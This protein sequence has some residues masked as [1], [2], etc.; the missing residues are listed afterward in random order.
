MIVLLVFT[1]PGI[2]YESLEKQWL[3]YC[4]LNPNITVFFIRFSQEIDDEYVIAKNEIIIRGT[5]SFVPGIYEK[6]IRSLQ[7]LLAKDE[8]DEVNFFV[9]SNISSFWIFDRLEKYLGTVQ[10]KKFV[11]TGFIAKYDKNEKKI[12]YPQGSG[13]IL[14]RDVVK[15]FSLELQNKN[16]N[17]LPD[18][19]AFGALCEK[20][21]IPISKYPWNVT[22][23]ITDPDSYTKYIETIPEDVI[24]IRNKITEPIL[25]MKYEEQKYSILL[26]YFY[27]LPIV[28]YSQIKIHS[29]I[30]ETNKL[31]IDIT[32]I[33]Q[34]IVSRGVSDIVI[35]PQVF[36]IYDFAPC[37]V[38]TLKINY[39][40][41]EGDIKTISKNDF[42]K[43]K[44]SDF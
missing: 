27:K 3:R 37:V 43:I 13:F 9:R 36:G 11:S 7:I 5:E 2:L 25:R 19:V 42:E 39:S 18:D 22:S 28:I 15:L 41:N 33:I 1:S 12:L 40:I 24:T 35:S 14:S 26:N 8:Y 10:T 31:S 6:T 32:T 17:I 20:H 44:F 23:H 16:V 21:N 38:K 34:S 4:N 30:Y 29:A